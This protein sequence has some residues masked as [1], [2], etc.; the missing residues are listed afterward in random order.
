MTF[1]KHPGNCNLAPS[2]YLVGARELI[3][4][5]DLLLDLLSD[6]FDHRAAQQIQMHAS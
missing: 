4:V 6:P 1:H 5:I 2:N 3:A